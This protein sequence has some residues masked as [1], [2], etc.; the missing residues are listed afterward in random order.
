MGGLNENAMLTLTASVDHAMETINDFQMVRKFMYNRLG[1]AMKLSETQE[2]M[3]KRYQFVYDQF[4]TG[5]YSES[6]IVHQLIAQFGIT[7]ATARQSIARAKELF[8]NTLSLKRLFEIKLDIETTNRL[9][10]KA[11]K[12]NRFDD[13]AKLMKVK[14][15]LYKLLPDEEEVPADYFEPR[16]NEFMYDPHLLGVEPVSQGEIQKVLD[17]LKVNFKIED[18]DFEIIKEADAGEESIS[19]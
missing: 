19:E 11:E 7:E 13:V 2:M 17:D 3:L 12:A 10:R 18:I 1:D 4:S 15:E 5:K 6:D 16:K 9:I 8:N 14:V